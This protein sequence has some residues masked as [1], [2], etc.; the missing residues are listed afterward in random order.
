MK[1]G[2]V[3]YV[4]HPWHGLL[5]TIITSICKSSTGVTYTYEHKFTVAECFTGST[6]EELADNVRQW[7]IDDF[8]R[9]DKLQ[10]DFEK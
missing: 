3:I 4:K 5:K 10:L 9:Q 1:I 7:V 2:D 8:I 6:I